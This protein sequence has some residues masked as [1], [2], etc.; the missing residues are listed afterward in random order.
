MNE[1]VAYG[2]VSHRIITTSK[3]E[4]GDFGMEENLA[5]GQLPCR[6]MN[7]SR[8]DAYGAFPGTEEYQ[9]VY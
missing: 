4:A 8:N 5:Y 3:N 2:E 9:D 7:M 1:N 6:S